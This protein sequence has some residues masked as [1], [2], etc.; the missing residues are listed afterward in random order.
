MTD[1]CPAEDQLVAL[2]EGRLAPGESAAVHHHVRGCADCR[3]ALAALG[4]SMD[5]AISQPTTPSSPD[6]DVPLIPGQRVGRFELTRL[7]GLGGMGAVWSAHDPDLGRDVAVKILRVGIG[8]DGDKA[9]NRRRLM[10]EAKAM[11]HLAHPNVV[12]VFEF[13][14]FGERLFV[15]LEL[16]E[17]ET[18]GRWLSKPRALP[19]ILEIFLAAGRG[20]AA[21]HAAGL[22]HRDF[23]PEN[24]LVGK[25]GRARV[26]D[27]GLA[28]SV[29]FDTGNLLP[30]AE[31]IADLGA[32]PS[33]MTPLGSLLGTPAY[34]SPEQMSGGRADAR[35]DLF[36][37]CTALY[38]AVAG[39]RPFPGATLKD[40]LERAQAQRIEPPR[41]PVPAWLKRV[42]LRGLAAD[43]AQRWASMDALLLALERG[44]S[45]RTT[46]G[47][48]AAALALIALAVLL[49]EARKIKPQPRRSLAVTWPRATDP[50][51]A[52]PFI[53]GALQELL[54]TELAADPQLRLFSSRTV[55]PALA[56]LGAVPGTPVDAKLA[57][58]LE[59]RLG[60][61]MVLGGWYRLGKSE[62]RVGISLWNRSDQPVFSAE[63]AA[64]PEAV[65]QLARLLGERLRKELGDSGNSE[66]AQ[67]SFPADAE[68]ARLYVLGV[69]RLRDYEPG[70]AIETLKK[71]EQLAPDNPRIELAMAEAQLALNNDVPAREAA[72]RA[73]EHKDDLPPDDRARLEILRERALHN[74]DKAIALARTFWA[75][76]PD[77]V[78]RGLGL[79][80]L[81]WQLAKDFKGAFATLSELRKRG[82]PDPRTGILEAQ[83]A[84]SAGDLQRAAP[85]A[86]RAY[87]LAKAVGARHEMAQALYAEG[88]A[89]R[90][91]GSDPAAAREK[92]HQAELIYRQT[93]DLGGAAGANNS[94]AAMLA[95]AGDLAGAQ[96]QFEQAL[97][98]F[99]QLG[100]RLDEGKTLHNL[101]IV[102]RRMRDL[103]GAI[104]RSHEAQTLFLEV[105]DRQSAANALATLGHL[106]QDIGDL[107]GA[108]TAL[109]ESA[110]IRRE[111]KDPV[112]IASLLGLSLVR[113]MQGDLAGAHIVYDEAEAAGAGQEKQHAAE[114]HETRA[115]LDFADD[116][117][118]DAEASAREGARLA[119]SLQAVDEAALCEA[120]LARTLVKEGKVS[121]A[122]A[123]V[124]RGTALLSK[125]RTA[126]ARGFLAAADGRTAAAEGNVQGAVESLR[127]A[128]DEASRAGV[129]ED[130]WEL[131]LALAEVEPAETRAAVRARLKTFAAQA[132]AQGFGLY[133]LFA[134]SAVTH[135]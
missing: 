25:D 99:R 45:R 37:Y 36:S 128:L 120:L 72:A 22:V 6:A 61:D 26:T 54:A 34:M 13:G 82:Q 5:D 46:R 87:E 24:V 58:D 119:T 10:R 107:P 115:Q 104:A 16:V 68:A 42:L 33:S 83:V 114:L 135:R 113:L 52:S 21:A 97:A 60:A 30:V 14:E 94:Q 69:S 90:R 50:H 76:A 92:L 40:Q 4:D 57:H 89:L 116:R 111:L 117:L 56:D 108:A 130:Q 79:A 81:Q 132:R 53:E 48:A 64:P 122:R 20:L 44:R 47:L 39:T 1:G 31:A 41:R 96:A 129:A 110:R 67:G 121:D 9:Q 133:A 102:L 7:L 43:P 27:F 73:F 85:A 62:L 78:E 84:T 18:L 38:E 51:A 23:K 100:D 86:R 17:G 29:A 131:R 126:I 123:A 3:I 71:A 11:A 134:E 59:R 77:D 103:P 2:A 88:A 95:D 112:L 125:S 49:F 127:A 63:E 74:R 80:L 118:A 19:E 75:Q 124:S 91:L 12:P 65:V 98:T 35:S 101:S 55:G 15:V 32:T 70:A 93:H 105:G 28:R 8:S 109:S 106:R 66:S